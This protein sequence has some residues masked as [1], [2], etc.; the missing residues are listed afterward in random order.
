[1]LKLGCKMDMA[2]RASVEKPTLLALSFADVVEV[3]K[4][5]P[6][7]RGFLHRIRGFESHRR[8]QTKA[9]IEVAPSARAE[10]RTAKAIQTFQ[11]HYRLLAVTSQGRNH[12]DLPFL[13]DRMPEVRK[14]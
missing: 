11:S 6:F 10:I 1:M 7:A 14:A 4:P 5:V 9:L 8:L 2:S 13:P 3:V 12:S